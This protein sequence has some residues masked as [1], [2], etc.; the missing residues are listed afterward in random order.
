EGDEIR[1]GL[2]EP[3]TDMSGIRRLDRQDPI[4]EG[5]LRH[6]PVALERELDVVGGDR[7]AVVESGPLAEPEL[8]DQAVGR[9]SPRL[10]ETGRLSV[11][12]HGLH[13]AI[14][15]SKEDY[16]RRD[17]ARGLRG[18]EPGGGDRGSDGPGQLALRRCRTRRG[19][20]GRDE[21]EDK[22]GE[23]DANTVHGASL[24]S[25]DVGSSG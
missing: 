22:C 15:Q 11:A 19:S 21:N 10:G 20:D 14:V 16:I 12:N 9:D 2:L 23:E 8:V 6:P 24:L 1:P 3:D 25:P 13:E 4:L 17:D 18:V 5:L 7:L